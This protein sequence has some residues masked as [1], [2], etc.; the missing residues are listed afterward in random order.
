[1][2]GT[3]KEDNMDNNDTAPSAA[4]N[5]TQSQDQDDTSPSQCRKRNL[6]TAYSINEENKR[7][8]IEEN[9]FN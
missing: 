1:M 4:E 9:V 3:Q 5:D 8:K 7:S 6:H 2:S